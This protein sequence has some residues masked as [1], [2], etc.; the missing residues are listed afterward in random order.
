MVDGVCVLL[1]TL[2]LPIYGE[3]CS[4]WLFSFA[5]E[6]VYVP[7]FWCF[8]RFLNFR[9]ICELCASGPFHSASWHS[10][11]T[12]KVLCTWAMMLLF[13]LW[14]EIIARKNKQTFLFSICW[15]GVAHDII[16]VILSVFLFRFYVFLILFMYVCNSHWLLALCHTAIFLFI[17]F[18]LRF[19]AFNFNCF[20][21]SLSFISIPNRIKVFV[22][23][24]RCVSY[25]MYWEEQE[26]NASESKVPSHFQLLFLFGTQFVLCNIRF[27][28]AEVEGRKRSRKRRHLH[29]GRFVP[30]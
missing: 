25:L 18:F 3:S 8:Q 12:H 6:C 24:M 19:A 15:R 23:L 5:F 13:C 1:S 4:S 9:L 2:L 20:F 26:K 22:S 30:Y 21:L 17:F 14:E 10:Q 11:Y 28:C 29:L 7:F 16:N 27:E